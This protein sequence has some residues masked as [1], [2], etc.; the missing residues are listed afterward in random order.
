MSSTAKNHMDMKGWDQLLIKNKVEEKKVSNRSQMFSR[1][2]IREIKLL[3]KEGVLSG[4]C[5]RDIYRELCKTGVLDHVETGARMTSNNFSQHA[6]NV[7]KELGIPEARREQITV[8]VG[9]CK[10]GYK[11]RKII[12]ELGLS[13]GQYEYLR[14]RYL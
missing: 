13:D 5:V 4:K 11:K 9:M 10:E 1:K 14:E 3:I 7:K 2:Q 8:F 12:S 6:C